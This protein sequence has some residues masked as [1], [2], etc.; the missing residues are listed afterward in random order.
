MTDTIPPAAPAAPASPD[1][2]AGAPP[3]LVPALIARGFSELTSVQRAVLDPAYSGRDLRVSSK[4]GSGKTVAL[5]FLI[6]PHLPGIAGT[7]AAAA[8]AAAAAPAK[9]T[10]AEAVLPSDD[11]VPGGPAEPARPSAAPAAPAAKTGPRALVLAPTRELAVQV[12]GELRWLLADVG[13]NVVVVTGGTSIALERRSLAARPEVVVGTPGRLLDHLEKNAIDASQVGVVVLDE[14]DQMLDLGFRDDLIAILGKTPTA[15]RTHLVSAT[16]SRAVMSL[17]AKYQRDPLSAEGTALGSAN[18]DIAHVVHLVRAGEIEAA[19][20]NLL[21]LAEGER[22]LVFVRTRAD[23]ADLAERL[24]GRGFSARGISGDLE[25]RDRTRT[26]DAFR[27]GAL[28]VLVATDV[29]ARGLD[30]PDVGMV[31][32]VGPPG[33]AEALTHRA[34]RT[35]RAGRKG[36]SVILA[37]QAAGEE[38]QRLLSRARIR[39]DVRPAP[40]AADVQKAH[41]EKL[42]QE[43]KAPPASDMDARLRMLSARLLGDFDPME[44]VYALLARLEARE[45]CSPMPLTPVAAVLP[46]G[47]PKY[48][49]RDRTGRGGATSSAGNGGGGIGGASTDRRPRGDYTTFRITWGERFGANTPRIL[50]VVCRRGGITSKQ[51]GAIRLGPEW[52][53]FDVEASS[54]EKFFEKAGRPDPSEPRLRIDRFLPRGPARAA[55]RR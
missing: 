29:A 52:S 25:Q 18:E 17:G 46:S 48:R 36:V 16:F 40:N 30:V 39:A 47:A 55:L 12:A 4:T 1:A 34:G 22:V 19:L 6:A 20:V 24:V 2:F 37:N 15:R 8:A 10:E 13:A 3:Q 32:H 42:E 54:A 45:V 31:I 35:G 53:T 33:D 9:V 50:A 51:V 26:L 41:D 5:G 14:A 23:T 44:L 7:A 43:L 38:V 11:E 49:E 27:S 21:L 28:T